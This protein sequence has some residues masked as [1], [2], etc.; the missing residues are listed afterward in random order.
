MPNIRH[1][2]SVPDTSEGSVLSYTLGFVASLILT[3]GAYTVVTSSNYSRGILIGVTAVLAIIQLFVQLY[4][5]LH[6]GRESKPRWNLIALSF[7]LMVV[8]I[9][10]IGS[11]W[12]MNNLSYNGGHSSSPSDTDSYIIKDEGFKR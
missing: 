1:H 8:L 7:A 11:I 2:D 6:L 12:I 3:F 9:V 5:F 10:V 4:F